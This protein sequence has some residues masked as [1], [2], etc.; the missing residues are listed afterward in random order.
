MT[1][2]PVGIDENGKLP[3]RARQALADD[4]G[5]PES[6]VGSALSA[7]YGAIVSAA[8]YGFGD[9][10]T[11]D[12]VALTAAIADASAG[13]K[14]ALPSGTF[15]LASAVTVDKPLHFFG[16]GTVLQAASGLNGWVTVSATGSGST[17]QGITFDSNDVARGA[18]YGSSAND[19]TVTGC[20]FTG[21]SDL[22]GYSSG[23]AAIKVGIGVRWK[24]IGNSFIN[25]GGAAQIQRA[26]ALNDTNVRDCI[27]SDNIFEDCFIGVTVVGQGHTIS[28]NVFRD[29]TDN[30]VYLTASSAAVIVRDIAVTG[31]TFTDCEEGVVIA[32]AG[33]ATTDWT[34]NIT[35]TGNIFRDWTVRGL[36][37]EGR[38]RNM[39]ISDN[40][41]AN[42][43]AA[44]GVYIGLRADQAATHLTENVTI[45]G[46][47]LRGKTGF[48]AIWLQALTQVLIASNVLDI[49]VTAANH[50]LIRVQENAANVVVRGN[51][52]RATGADAATAYLVRQSSGTATNC[53][54]DHNTTTSGLPIALAG[55]ATTVNGV[56]NSINHSTGCETMPRA[57][58]GG[59]ASL[60]AGVLWLTYFTPSEAATVTKIAT[61]T[62]STAA[63]GATLARLGLYTVAPD[64]RP[65]LVAS[66]ASDTTL[67]TATNTYYEKA[68]SS[69]YT[70]IPG[71]RY[72]IGI[73]TVGN[74]TPP[75]LLGVA[76][77]VAGVMGLEPRQASAVSSQTDLPSSVSPPAATSSAFWAAAVA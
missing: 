21:Y 25:W 72:A 75:A 8:R 35:V 32:G 18:L 55:W 48:A 24:I 20:T 16:Q 41:F 49:E 17:F 3:T 5:N 9:G 39:V 70:L 44:P 6:E 64:G 28:G 11:G 30:G 36:S 38:I 50:H 56:G 66:T 61:A 73:I 26:V 37:F 62:R 53:R 14:I 69:S 19:V 23:D 29:C 52:L 33:V 58:L 13:D 2:K 45:T 12:A 27:V 63:V 76:S 15:T 7:S 74:S 1:Y 34:E 47:T 42:G 71:Q 57:T 10:T 54:V 31:N 46:N 40:T 22:N 60:S 65:T 59:S 43:L 68:L 77:N 4:M 51:I 67:W